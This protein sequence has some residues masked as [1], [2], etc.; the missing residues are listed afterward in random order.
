MK[1]FWYVTVIFKNM[2]KLKNCNS[3]PGSFMENCQFFKVFWKSWIPQFF[4]YDYFV[5]FPKNPNWQFFDFGILKKGFFLS[6][7]V[8]KLNSDSTYEESVA[9]DLDLANQR[10]P[11]GQFLHAKVGTRTK[12]WLNHRQGGAFPKCKSKLGYG[13]IIF[14]ALFWECP[15]LGFM[16]H[17]SYFISKSWM[18]HKSFAQMKSN[19]NLMGQRLSA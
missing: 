11:S 5:F 16:L 7:V 2:K 4:D 6:L 19:D 17:K 9:L 1:W 12:H 18:V 8:P 10:N 13:L 14:W 15:D 3:L